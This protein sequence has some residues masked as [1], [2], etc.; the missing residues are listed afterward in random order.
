ML[1]VMMMMMMVMMMVMMVMMVVMMMVM[2][3]V[4]TVIMVVMVVI[5]MAMMMV[6]KVTKSMG[7]SIL[8]A[9]AS[10]PHENCT[11]VPT[12]PKCQYFLLYNVKSF[13][14]LLMLMLFWV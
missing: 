8:S 10:Y 4:M 2:M 7:M 3:M 6:G 14:H 11:L 5:I 12:F 9:S 1:M 13:L